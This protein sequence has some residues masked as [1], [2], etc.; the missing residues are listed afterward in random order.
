MRVVRS[1][2]EIRLLVP[3][4]F[5]G[6]SSFT[7]SSMPE[8]YKTECQIFSQEQIA[9][10]RRGGKILHDCLQHISTLVHPGVTTAELDRK[11]EA[12]IREQ[13]GEPAFKGYHNYPATLCTSV[14]DECVH[15][16]PNDDGLKEGDI[17][18]L[19][20]GVLFDGLYT[21][22]CTTVPVGKISK[23]AEKLLTATQEALA[24]GLQKVRAGGYTGDV[25]AAIHETLLKAGFDAMR[26][27]TGHGLGDTLHQFPD[28]PNFGEAG[29]GHV[30]PANTIVAIE[31]ISTAGS[32]D[33]YEDPD[34][35]TLRTKDRA[36]SAHFEHTVLVGEGGCEVLTGG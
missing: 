25:S 20:C 7:L 35:W 16:L 22:S 13:G 12:F 14:N 15:G 5:K 30:L 6:S 28:I 19:D 17:V 2:S 10:L 34:G 18:A 11:A 8:L 36:L 29:E 24:A 31:P 23:E 33:I 27:L 21:D 3:R 26:P 1:V 4:L 32:T 9:S